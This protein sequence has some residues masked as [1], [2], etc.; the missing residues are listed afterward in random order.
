VCFQTIYSHSLSAY[1]LGSKLSEY[2]IVCASLRVDFLF[3][4]IAFLFS[5]PNSPVPTSLARLQRSVWTRKHLSSY[6]S[7]YSYYHPQSHYHEF[8]PFGTHQL[9]VDSHDPQ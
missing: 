8:G 9:D 4:V 3:S 7:Q 2:A 1:C 6:N 5:F